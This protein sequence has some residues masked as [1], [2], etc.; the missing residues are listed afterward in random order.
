MRLGILALD[1]IES[2]MLPTI[3]LHILGFRMTLL[4]LCPQETKTKEQNG[5]GK[6]M[7]PTKYHFETSDLNHKLQQITLDFARI[8]NLN[9]ISNAPSRKRYCALAIHHKSNK[10]LVVWQRN[11]VF[12]LYVNHMFGQQRSV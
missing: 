10:H 11:K 5:A 2:Q 1:E 3:T 6:W 9:P 12:G 7:R 4:G 8:P